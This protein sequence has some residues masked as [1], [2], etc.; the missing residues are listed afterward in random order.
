MDKIMKKSYLFSLIYYALEK[1]KFTGQIYNNKPFKG[2]IYDKY[3]NYRTTNNSL[4]YNGEICYQ[5]NNIKYFG[6]IFKNLPHGY[7]Q[8][9]IN[10]K[11]VY[12]GYFVSGECTG[13]G[14]IF[15]DKE[16]IL[17]FGVIRNN[18]PVE[19]IFIEK[20]RVFE[21]QIYHE[22]NYVENIIS[23]DSFDEHTNTI[24][25]SNEILMHLKK[26]N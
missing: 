18:M 14:Y 15:T 22:D 4:F 24:F 5:S 13:N 12:M 11:I 8:L 2:I 7:G 20:K 6:S 23:K 10:N 9:W 1:K 3:K 26:A 17:F 19:G 21:G 16:K 25:G